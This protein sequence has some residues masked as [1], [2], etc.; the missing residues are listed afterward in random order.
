[1]NFAK[2]AIVLVAL[3]G[4]P[5][6]AETQTTAEKD[7]LTVDQALKVSAGLKKISG[8]YETADKDK[9]G[10]YEYGADVRML[11]AANIDIGS[12]V[13]VRFE[14]AVNDLR[15][16]YLRPPCEGADA[17]CNSE[18]DRLNIEFVREI[19][20]LGDT[21]SLVGYWHIPLK[22]LCLEAAPPCKAANPI[23][24]TDLALIMPIIDR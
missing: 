23:P 16:K 10:F 24:P 14:R 15:A 22:S 12:R 18:R 2:A 13:E 4:G 21:P 6:S 8:K 5:V 19:G 17:A 9:P 7:A 1:M 11:I 3:A 20:K